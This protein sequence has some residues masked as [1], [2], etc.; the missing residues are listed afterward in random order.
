MRVLFIG[1]AAFGSDTLAALVEQGEEVVGV[2]TG[3]GKGDAPD[4]VA[5]KAA[6]LGLPVLTTSSLK[7]PEV[8]DWIAARRPDLMCLAYVT[9][10]V[11]QSLIDLAPL[12]GINYHPSLLP[13]HRGG[14]AMNWAILQGDQETGVTIHYID[15]GIDTGDIILQE[16]VPIDPDDSV[17]T[18][19]FQKLYPLGVKLIAR[20]VALIREGKAPRIPQDEAQATYEPLITEED[21]R[22]DWTRP[23]PELYRVVRAGDPAPGAVTRLRGEKLKIWAARPVE[24]PSPADQK[25]GTIVAVNPRGFVVQAGKGALQVERVQ[26]PGTKKIPAPELATMLGL[27]PGEV[28]G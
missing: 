1:Q 12:G 23:A 8:A 17:K 18:L 25:P 3:K 14:S 24:G 2:I 28:L 27:K 21:L 9:W 11:P 7:T 10:I 4:P 6:E 5:V 22:L 13:R 16:K 20:A 15:A 19:Y 26:Y